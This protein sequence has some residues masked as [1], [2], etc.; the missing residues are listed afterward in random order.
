[1]KGTISRVAAWL[2]LTYLTLKGICA[3]YAV[4]FP[5]NELTASLSTFAVFS[6]TD[7]FIILLASAPLLCSAG[8]SDWAIWRKINAGMRALRLVGTADGAHRV[9]RDPQTIR[10]LR[11]EVRELALR[12]RSE[13]VG[14]SGQDLVSL[15]NSAEHLS[16]RLAGTELELQIAPLLANL[17]LGSKA[18]ALVA[19]ADANA[20]R[21]RDSGLDLRANSEDEVAL[22]ERMRLLGYRKQI[23]CIA[24]ILVRSTGPLLEAGETS[25]AH[26]R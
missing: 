4:A 26:L 24:E 23:V 3:Y 15:C 6:A 18:T 17:R 7:G 11:G 16:A 9:E 22:A 12:C 2:A 14:S 8:A 20:R 19:T 1:M 25:E 21:L 13:L 5:P 10:A